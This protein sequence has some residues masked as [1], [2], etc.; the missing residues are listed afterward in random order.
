MS[1]Q[2]KK[3]HIYAYMEVVRDERRPALL[4]GADCARLGLVKR[5]HAVTT[6]D[7]K[8]TILKSHPQLFHGSGSLPGVHTI[9][10]QDDAAPVIHAP[11]RVEVAKRPQLKRELDRQV[12]QGFLAKVIESTDWVNSLVIVEKANGKMR[13]CIKI[14]PKDL[15]K[16]VK[17]EHFQ[18]PTKEEILGKLRDAK[19]FSKT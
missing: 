15:N 7:M 10:L 4:G 19:W 3:R 17:R 11:R 12:S 16:V 18:I 14:D 5:V 8:A 2:Y 9:V 1:V 13:L 6:K